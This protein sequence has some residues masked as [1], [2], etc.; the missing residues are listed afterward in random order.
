[1]GLFVPLDQNFITLILV[2]SGKSI[3]FMFSGNLVDFLCSS[4]V[5]VENT[6]QQLGS[7]HKFAAAAATDNLSFL[8]NDFS[9]MLLLH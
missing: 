3:C 9:S 6:S 7:F 4:F 5:S 1:M 8:K 2:F